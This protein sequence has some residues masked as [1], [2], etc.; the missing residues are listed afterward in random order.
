MADSCWCRLL[1]FDRRSNSNLRTSLQL[2]KFF[3][4]RCTHGLFVHN[5]TTLGLKFCHAPI[6]SCCILTSIEARTSSMPYQVRKS[7]RTSWGRRHAVLL[8][9]PSTLFSGQDR[10]TNLL[11]LR[12]MQLPWCTAPICDLE[13]VSAHVYSGM[14]GQ[15]SHVGQ[16][17]GCFPQEPWSF[18]QFSDDWRLSTGIAP[19]H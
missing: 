8:V 5:D 17:Y 13:A 2:L 18:Y 4:R 6:V 1:S 14:D 15:V 19:K 12:R 3:D 10:T 11:A 16:I 7:Y 9:P